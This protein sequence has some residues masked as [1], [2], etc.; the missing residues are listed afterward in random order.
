MLSDFA[1]ILGLPGL[2]PWTARIS[3]VGSLPSE[4]LLLY[5]VDPD[6]SVMEH[7]CPFGIRIAFG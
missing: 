2:A 4:S 5:P 6:R 3:A 1:L 7:G